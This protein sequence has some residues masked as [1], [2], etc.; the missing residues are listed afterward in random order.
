M[1][2]TIYN[3]FDLGY[4]SCLDG[5]VYTKQNNLVAIAGNYVVKPADLV[6]LKY[7]TSSS[8]V[9]KTSFLYDDDNIKNGT[10]HITYTI[11]EMMIMKYGMLKYGF[12]KEFTSS[13]TNNKEVKF[14]L[15][16]TTGILR[17]CVCL[18][19]GVQHYQNNMELT[20]NG[21]TQP[22]DTTIVISA[23]QDPY[24]GTRNSIEGFGGFA[25]KISNELKGKEII[26]K[27]SSG[28]DI[29]YKYMFYFLPYV[30]P[31]EEI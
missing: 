19:T 12:P 14:N 10:G 15:P 20:I 16:N 18:Q 17:L 1:L 28:T 22:I 4:Y 13:E 6:R 8:E 29:R 31:V 30:Y 2:E 27:Q 24:D 3:N 9:F 21:V 23:L 11:D 7:N 26:F 25:F 5:Y